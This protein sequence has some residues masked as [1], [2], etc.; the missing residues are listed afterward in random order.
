MQG[1]AAACPA[2]EEEARP[3]AVAVEQ[4]V[5]L[6]HVVRGKSRMRM[7]VEVVQPFQTGQIRPGP[8][9]GVEIVLAQRRGVELDRKFPGKGGDAVRVTAEVEAHRGQPGLLQPGGRDFRDAEKTAGRGGDI[10]DDV[11]AECRGF[12]EEAAHFAAQDIGPGFGNLQGRKNPAETEGG[13]FVQQPPVFTG[14]VV[15]ARIEGNA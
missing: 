4:G 1:R 3:Q 9:Q 5:L 10:G 11:Q 7:G 12:A 15:Q 8:A 6:L 14:C 13:R 2:G